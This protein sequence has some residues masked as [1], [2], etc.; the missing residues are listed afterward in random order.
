MRRF[1]PDELRLFLEA[2][3]RHLGARVRVIIIGGS[4]AALAYDVRSGTTDVDTFE[5]DL[6]ALS[7]ALARARVET[8]LHIPFVPAGVADMPWEYQT[9]LVRE[10]AHLERLD[11]RVPER[12]DL[13]LSKALRCHE[14][15][16]QVI[17]DMHAV[18]PFQLDTLVTRFEAELGH[19]VGA[20][21]RRRLNFLACVERLFG[22]I[23]ADDVD[24]RLRRTTKR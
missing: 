20:P 15:D 16:L 10:L 7:D 9:R 4:A 13:A 18:E 24:R 14:G 17:E 23:V 19:A 11:V 5:T 21:E 3:D 2:V 6:H 1:T 12:H 8:G 22:E